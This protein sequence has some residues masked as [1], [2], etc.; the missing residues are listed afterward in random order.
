MSTIDDW[1]I[2]FKQEKDT[3]IRLFCFHYGGGSASAYKE[4]AKDITERVD[5]VAVQLPGRENRFG[6]HLL[7]NA[8]QVADELH[9]NFDRYLKKPFVFFGHSIRGFN[10]F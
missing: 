9:K 5:L 1:F 7:D 6:E 2:P 10:S 4:W 8:F 3:Y